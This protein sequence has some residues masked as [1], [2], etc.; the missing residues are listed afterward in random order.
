MDE[1]EDAEMSYRRGFEQAPSI[2]LKQV[3][4]YLPA[5]VAANTRYWARSIKAWR[6]ENLAGEG[7]RDDDCA[8]PPSLKVPN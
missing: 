8:G 2:L 3:E 1:F 5:S 7:G 6:M 4:L